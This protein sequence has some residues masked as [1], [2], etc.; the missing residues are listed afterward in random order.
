MIHRLSLKL[1]R[2]SPPCA[3]MLPQYAVGLISGKTQLR[4]QVNCEKATCL[5]WQSR[6]MSCNFTRNSTTFASTDPLEWKEDWGVKRSPS[7]GLA[8]QRGEAVAV[9]SCPPSLTLQ[10][11]YNRSTSST[12]HLGDA[13]FFPLHKQP[14]RIQA[15]VFSPVV[16]SPGHDIPPKPLG[17]VS[18]VSEVFTLLFSLT[19]YCL[20][21]LSEG[22]IGSSC[23]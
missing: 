9:N 1:I 23:Y 10:Q 13:R 6:S 14:N 18:P 3:H 15:R 22:C 21:V 19:H 4:I 2:Y 7:S 20:G 5:S 11:N 8:S 12:T 16:R 17:Y